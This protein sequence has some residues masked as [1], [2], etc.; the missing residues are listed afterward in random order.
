ME[1][2][3][4]YPH[5]LSYFSAQELAEIDQA[6][7]YS[8]LC[9]Y[10][11]EVLKRMPP[12]VHMVCGPITTGGAGSPEANLKRFSGAIDILHRYNYNV[13]TQMP[14]E[15]PMHRLQSLDNHSQAS[16]LQLLTEFY[17][18]VFKS[19]KVTYLCFLPDWQTSFGASWE[20]NRGTELVLGR[21]YFRDDFEE[22]HPI[23][24]IE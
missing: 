16:A 4:I 13:F 23:L 19:G 18:P 22:G 17:L 12:G 6:A 1:T 2:V 20:H 14:F 3:M 11:L 24:W 21:K 8:T 15:G 10:A 5:P 9:G 7:S